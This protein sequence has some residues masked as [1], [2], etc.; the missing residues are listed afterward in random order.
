MN[1]YPVTG[2]IMEVLPFITMGTQPIRMAGDGNVLGLRLRL[3]PG[4][5][6]DG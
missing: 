3:L 5:V 2:T 1:T 6:T 4:N